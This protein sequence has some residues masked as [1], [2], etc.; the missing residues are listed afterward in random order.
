M[1]GSRIEVFFFTRTENTTWHNYKGDGVNNRIVLVYNLMTKNTK[2][3]CE[4]DELNYNIV[5]IRELINPYIYK[6][7]KIY[8]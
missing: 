3:V 4:I 6:Y 7:F 8:W 5:T 2:K 1:D